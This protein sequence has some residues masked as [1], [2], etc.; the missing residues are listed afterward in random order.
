MWP[1]REDD[2]F[3]AAEG[4]YSEQRAEWKCT[5]FTAQ[6][7]SLA[8]AYKKA[9]HEGESAYQI[10]PFYCTRFSFFFSCPPPPPSPPNN[11]GRQRRRGGGARQQASNPPDD[12]DDDD[13]A[14]KGPDSKVRRGNSG[15]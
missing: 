1:S 4:H 11:A 9:D 13:D 7:L 3:S 6:F 14:K 8:A 15:V 12:D 10:T 5:R 2:A